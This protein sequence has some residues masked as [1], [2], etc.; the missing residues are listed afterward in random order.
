MPRARLALSCALLSLLAPCSAVLTL[1]ASVGSHMVLQRDAPSTSLW[2]TAAPGA[3]VTATL[4]P[5]GGAFPSS[6]ADADGVWRVPLPARPASL[7]PSNIT[8]SA[9]GE[10]PI[11][12]TDVLWGDVLLCH[13]Q[14]NLQLS[15]AMALNASAEINATAA[16]GAGI[17]VLLLGGSADA[18]QRD[19][20]LARAWARAS[21]AA[22]G[23]AS[24]A[25]FSAQCWF[26]GRAL[27]A[28]LGGTVPVG[29]IE[30][31]VGGTAIRQW[32]S[33][34]AL[35]ACP[36]PYTSP[37]PYGTAP[38]AHSTLFN[39]MV[40]GLGT[41]P[42][43]LRAVVHN[44]AES[45]SF[46]QTPI[47]YYSCAAV[48]QIASYRA[49]LRAPA[50][51]WVF[52]HL[53]PY[54]GAGPCCLE[55]L[56]GQQTTALALPA[57][58]YASAVDLGDVDSPWG[59]VHFRDKQTSGA[60]AAAALLALAYDAAQAPPGLA[61]PPPQFFSQTAFFDNATGTASIDVVFAAAG[62][63]APGAGELVLLANASVDCPASIAAENCTA[64]EVIGSDG[65]L[66]AAASA[67]L[68]GGTLTVTAQLPHGV[69]GAG[70]A[71]A[72]SMWPRVLL[73]FGNGPGG[74]NDSASLP[75][76]PW[77]QALM[78]GGPPPPR[79]ATSR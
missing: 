74:A 70:T 8:F 21:P 39:G 79:P 13:G 10:A 15:L 61:Y 72:W 37:V 41:G 43:A 78:L 1:S 75:V 69:Y 62:G 65:N 4:S 55:D 24:W 11:V 35:A 54:T 3:V 68:A 51:P 60:R 28:A 73:Y 36:Q 44:Q 40:A 32:S 2:G 12:I 20:G 56:R 47:G 27:F 18:P 77:R 71:S 64:F 66:Y 57:V 23:Q 31:A 38:Y 63:A 29:L 42:T 25:G 19:V 48:A 67:A 6:P 53:Q 7:I 17:R 46:P 49:L 9:A 22:M 50:L 33:T 52:V 16:F 34:G 14:S 30:A 45:D 5:S 58:G 59:N 76:L 26:T